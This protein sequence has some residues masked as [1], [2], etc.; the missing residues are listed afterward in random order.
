MNILYFT[1]THFTDNPLEFYR[2]KIIRTLEDLVDRYA[3][4][5][6]YHLGDIV[7]RKDRHAGN[8]VNKLIYEFKALTEC[9]PVS[10]LSGN[11]D[12]PLNLKDPY[13]WEFLNEAGIE[14]ITQPTFSVENNMWLLPFTSNPVV[15]WK[16]LDFRSAKAVLMHQTLPG[17]MIENDRILEKGQTLPIFPK[18]CMIFSGDVHRPQTFGGV[19]YIGAPH[20]VRFSENWNNRVI[21]VNTDNFYKYTEIPVTSIKR[22]ILDI[23][24]SKELKNLPYSQGDQLRIRYKISSSKLVDWPLEQDIIKN[25]CLEKGVILMSLEASLIGDGLQATSEQQKNDIETMKP[26]QVVRTFAKQEKLSQDVIDMG[27]ELIKER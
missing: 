19:V 12:A 3:V 11:H 7:D 6:L 22:A 16:E 1:D 18:D 21:L 27:L 25:W 24:S 17:V 15:D 8:L 13:Y 4:K 5:H 23:E 9:C 2:W 26:D 20:P 10:I 14:Y